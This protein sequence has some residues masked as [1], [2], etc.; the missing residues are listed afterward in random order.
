MT[1]TDRARLIAEI[2]TRRQ[3]HRAAELAAGW[4]DVHVDALI[5]EIDA[6]TA[7]RHSG[8]AYPC[9]HGMGPWRKIEGCPICDERARCEAVVNAVRD[10]QRRIADARVAR[11]RREIGEFIYKPDKH[12]WMTGWG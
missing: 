8:L 7:D 12:S 4:T 10:D 11:A 9:G 6:L 5:E 2:V 1:S 3:Q